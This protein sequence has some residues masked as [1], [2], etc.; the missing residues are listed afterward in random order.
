MGIDSG[1][2]EAEI[3]KPLNSSSRQPTPSPALRSSVGSSW[4]LESGSGSLNPSSLTHTSSRPASRIDSVA[5]SDGNR[6]AGRV[7]EYLIIDFEIDIIPSICYLSMQPKHKNA[8]LF[9]KSLGTFEALVGLLQ[10]MVVKP[11]FPLRGNGPL[12][13]GVKEA[14]DSSGCLLLCDMYSDRPPGLNN[15]LIDLAIHLEWVNDP[16]ISQSQTQQASNIVLLSRRQVQDPNWPDLVAS[17][18]RMIILS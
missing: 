16:S 13:K 14:L 4:N 8:V 18:R 5:D 11:V 9:V 17:M 12:S 6:P 15:K 3:S 2:N 1:V 10:K 7:A